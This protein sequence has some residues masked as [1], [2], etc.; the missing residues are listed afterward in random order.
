MFPAH[1]G[2]NRIFS[3]LLLGYGM[4]PAHAGMNRIGFLRYTHRFNVPRTRGDEPEKCDE[5]HDRE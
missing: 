1:A 3:C 4:F 5:C 2:M